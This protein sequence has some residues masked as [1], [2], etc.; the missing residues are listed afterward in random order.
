MS[1][2]NCEI[3]MYTLRCYL[4]DHVFDDIADFVP[5]RSACMDFCEV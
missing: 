4:L 1:D 5:G 3:E 2:K